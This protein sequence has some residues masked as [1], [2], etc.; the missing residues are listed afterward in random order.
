MSLDHMMRQAASGEFSPQREEAAELGWLRFAARYRTL[1]WLWGRP[2]PVYVCVTVG[3]TD[4][5]WN[6]RDGEFDGWDRALCPECRT[7]F[8]RRAWRTFRWIL[9]QVREVLLIM[10]KFEHPNVEDAKRG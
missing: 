9:W 5:L 6:I 2:R 8:A 3:G 4:Y 1:P 10:T 7:R